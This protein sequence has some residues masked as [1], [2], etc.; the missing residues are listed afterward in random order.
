MSPD[1]LTSDGI[2]DAIMK[3][4]ESAVAQAT[5]CDVSST[6]SRPVVEPKVEAKPEPAA[7]DA[8]PAIK[9]EEVVLA[10]PDVGSEVQIADDIC[11]EVEVGTAAPKE[12]APMDVDVTSVP[13]KTVKSEEPVVCTTTTTT[14]TQIVT[15]QTVTTVGGVVSSVE[16][17]QSV[18]EAASTQVAT[19]SAAT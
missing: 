3:D 2:S 6:A 5:T 9:E 11:S 12:D 15:T 19:T 17:S 16:A 7:M 8:E 10:T 1:E 13:S 4:L 18:S 14:S